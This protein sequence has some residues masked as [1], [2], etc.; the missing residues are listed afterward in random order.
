MRRGRQALERMVVTHTSEMY[1]WRH[2]ASFHSTTL[3]G[4]DRSDFQ[5]QYL[6]PNAV[7]QGP[8]ATPEEILES[9]MAGI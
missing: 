5:L 9:V 4:L 3:L 2:L 8:L 1:L 6:P 7:L